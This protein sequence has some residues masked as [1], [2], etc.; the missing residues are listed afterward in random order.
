M[1]NCPEWSDGALSGFLRLRLAAA[2]AAAAP[3]AALAADSAGVGERLSA[4]R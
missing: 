3:V 1:G 2:A 4:D